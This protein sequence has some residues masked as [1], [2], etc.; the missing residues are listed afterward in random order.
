MRLRP[1]APLLAFLAALCGAAGACSELPLPPEL[2]PGGEP[3]ASVYSASGT[4]RTLAYR[5]RGR[6][7]YEI[8]GA[9]RAA[10]SFD[11]QF[12]APEL[13]DVRVLLTDG[14][15]REG[16]VEVGPLQETSGAQRWTFTV[17]PG[18]VW[19]WVLLWSAELDV[20]IGRAPLDP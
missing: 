1:A 18:A 10:L 11:A 15:T 19:R 6:A 20:E 2:P 13:P 14:G 8:D 9:G 16:A 17:P 5:T 7:T 4:F 3:D 12:E